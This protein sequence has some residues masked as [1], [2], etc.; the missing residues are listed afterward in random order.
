MS[1]QIRVCEND[2][3]ETI[4]VDI[5]ETSHRHIDSSGADTQMTSRVNFMLSTV[6]DKYDQPPRRGS[7]SESATRNS[8]YVNSLMY[9]GILAQSNNCGARETAAARER[10]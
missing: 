9:C 4:R 8:Q 5:A 10:L 2:S 6:A 7:F 1:D 3:G